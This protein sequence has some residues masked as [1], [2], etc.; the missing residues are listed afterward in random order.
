MKLKVLNSQTIISFIVKQ[1]LNNSVW[2]KRRVIES[3]FKRFFELTLV[4]VKALS[5]GGFFVYS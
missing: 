3:T 4:V 5:R 1:T 2:G